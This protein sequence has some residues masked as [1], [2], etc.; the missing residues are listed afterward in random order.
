[1]LD[2]I[3]YFALDFGGPPKTAGST[4]RQQRQQPYFPFVFIELRA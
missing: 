4:G 1:V 2:L 3:E